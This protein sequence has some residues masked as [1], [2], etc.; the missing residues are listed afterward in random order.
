MARSALR[1]CI[2]LWAIYLLLLALP[3][4]ASNPLSLYDALF[5][6]AYT[7][8][9]SFSAATISNDNVVGIEPMNLSVSSLNIVHGKPPKP[10]QY[11]GKT[12]WRADYPKGAYAGAKDIKEGWSFYVNGSDDFASK[13]AAGA[14]EAVIGYSVYFEEGFDFQEGG[15]IPGACEYR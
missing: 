5:P 1:S 10:M 15:K 13:C 3:G 7:Y 9:S 14:K 2:G 12:T 4:K 11:A 8:S 6:S